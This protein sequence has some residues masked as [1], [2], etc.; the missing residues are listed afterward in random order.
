[1]SDKPPLDLLAEALADPPGPWL[2]GFTLAHWPRGSVVAMPGDA[3]DRTLL[4]RSGRLRVYLSSP[5]RELTLAWLEPGELYTTHTPT[6]I[7]AV[8]D[9]SAWTLPTRGFAARLAADPRATPVLMRVLGRLLHGAVQRIED[10]ALREVP[11]RLARFLVEQ[12]ARRGQ[13]QADGGVRLRL[14]LSLEDIASLLGSTRQT[15]S[16]LVN[17]WEREGLIARPARRVL[18]LS[19]PHALQALAAG[20][21]PAG[22]GRVS[23]GAGPHPGR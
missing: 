22:A 2:D 17:Q 20:E 1:M 7:E 3:R 4:L 23:D 14:E 13:P 8:A 10:L 5:Q 18:L 9:S 19:R 21:V 15:V 12:A 6:W 16:A 11:A